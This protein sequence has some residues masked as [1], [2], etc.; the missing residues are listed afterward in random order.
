MVEFYR[1]RP[2]IQRPPIGILEQEFAWIV[3]SS[4]K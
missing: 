1:N 4:D 3:E 2:K